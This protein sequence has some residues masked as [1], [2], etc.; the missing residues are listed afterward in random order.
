MK[1]QNGYSGM[2]LISSKKRGMKKS[3]ELEKG[4]KSEQE[5]WKR[6]G[7]FNTILT[8]DERRGAARYLDVWQENDQFIEFLTSTW[9]DSDSLVVNIK[10]FQTAVA[11]RN[12]EIFG[13]IGQRKKMIKARLRGIDRALSVR[14]SDSMVALES[15]LKS[16]LEEILI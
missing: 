16:E 2:R 3:V 12:V 10:R 6:R 14:H 11:S 13:H 1:L 7:D 15:R 5:K 9:V 8:A 4:D